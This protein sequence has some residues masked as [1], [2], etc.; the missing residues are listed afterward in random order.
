MPGSG[1]YGISMGDGGRLVRHQREIGHSNNYGMFDARRQREGIQV[2][3]ERR[4]HLG[5]AQQ[6]RVAGGTR[7]TYGYGDGSGLERNR[8]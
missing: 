8:A 5:S 4:Q 6:Q 2:D 3:R 1:M 7:G